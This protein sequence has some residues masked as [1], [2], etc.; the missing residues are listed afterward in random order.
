MTRIL[1]VD[2]EPD[3][4][5]V[6]TMS[7]QFALDAD[8]NAVAS[9]T[10]AY[11]FLE[12]NPVPDIIVLDRM[13]PEGDG[14]EVCQRLRADPRFSEVPIVFLTGCTEAE[15]ERRAMEAGANACLAK[16]FD[17]MAIGPQIADVLRRCA[18]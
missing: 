14:V 11:A 10:E 8:V 17:P 1:C 12:R 2:D 5:Q 4:R 9:A 6:L 18:A 3:I 13:L 15:D 7:L 16:P